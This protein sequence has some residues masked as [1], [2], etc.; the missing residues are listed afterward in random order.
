MLACRF[1]PLPNEQLARADL[2][3][4]EE[5]DDND[6]NIHNNNNDDKKYFPNFEQ[7]NK[8]RIDLLHA[9]SV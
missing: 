3:D 6:D 1:S 8:K 9:T 2:N 5:E 7:F 4:D